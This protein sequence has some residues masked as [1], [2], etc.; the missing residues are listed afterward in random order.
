MKRRVALVTGASGGIGRAVA[1]ALAE[2]GYSIGIHYNEN[3]AAAEEV[4]EIISDMGQQSVTLCADVS[5]RS[6]V[7][8]MVESVRICL[9]EIDVLV[10]C[11]GVADV[12]LFTDTSAQD[13]DRLMNINLTGVFNCCRLVVPGMI[14]RGSGCIINL[15]SVWGI[16][17]AS[18]EVGYSA[19]KAGII[20]LTQALAKELGPSGIRVNCVAPGYIET[21]MN[22]CFDAAAVADIVD[23]TPLGRVGTPEDVARAISFLASENA[24]FITGATL[25]VTG[26]FC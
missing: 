25:P 3:R 20:G 12:R 14:T 2:A 17:G 5:D 7:E 1:L 19:T 4:S 10:N 9:G 16:Y 15:S 18:C 21:G 13:W 8:T 24:S 6:K 26:G 23:R 11:A 22:S